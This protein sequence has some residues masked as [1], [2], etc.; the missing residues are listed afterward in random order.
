[1]DPTHKAFCG[2]D[3]EILPMEEIEKRAVVIALKLYRGNVAEAAKKLGMGNATLYRR[4]KAYKIRVVQ[5]RKVLVTVEV[6]VASE[7]G[8]EVP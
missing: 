6:L 4:M 8:E 3:G 1:M 5:T 2:E 7:K